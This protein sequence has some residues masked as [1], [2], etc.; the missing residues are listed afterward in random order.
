[1]EELVKYYK[2][3]SSIFVMDYPGV[4]DKDPTDEN[5][6]IIPEVSLE[7]LRM[8]KKQNS[9]RGITDVTGGLIGKIECAMEM[10]KHSET[11]ITNLDHLDDCLNGKPKGSRVIS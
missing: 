4:F 11:W 10:A 6:M 5:S 3:I 9:N 2:P 8:L 1:M 7:T